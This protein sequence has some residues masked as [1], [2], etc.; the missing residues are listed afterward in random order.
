M[1][2]R[3]V[4]ISINEIES[5]QASTNSNDLEL[6]RAVA[7][8]EQ[9]D[10]KLRFPAAELKTKFLEHLNSLI[11]VSSKY[12][13]FP[14]V[15]PSNSNQNG[16]P[17]QVLQLLPLEERPSLQI[18]IIISDMPL[19]TLQS[20]QNIPHVPEASSKIRGVTPASVVLTK[21]SKSLHQTQLCTIIGGGDS[22]QTMASEG[23]A[24]QDEAAVLVKQFEHLLI[25]EEF[26]GTSALILEW[27]SD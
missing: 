13:A 8:D 5:I 18:P 1:I 26:W 2:S 15:P 4:S 23:I 20:T 7:V 12:L 24:L 14:I 21:K 17:T 27:M 10:Y 16:N 6:T 9:I 22:S 19:E 3:Q 25:S 11:V